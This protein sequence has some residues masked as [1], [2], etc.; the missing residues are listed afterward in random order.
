M[1]EQA[2]EQQ[3]PAETP[4]PAEPKRVRGHHAQVEP[5]TS[6]A[7]ASNVNPTDDADQYAVEARDAKVEEMAA[8]Y[9]SNGDDA[10]AARVRARFQDAP[11][12]QPGDT[13]GGEAAPTV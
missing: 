13:T 1:S 6:K 3:P 2:P 5:D 11:A 8:R 10:A 7:V 4:P 9:E 12:E